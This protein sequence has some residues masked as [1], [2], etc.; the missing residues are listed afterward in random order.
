MPKIFFARSP[1][2]CHMGVLSLNTHMSRNKLINCVETI[3]ILS[4][5][6]W[7]VTTCTS[8]STRGSQTT[9]AKQQN[10][11]TSNI[12][13][14]VTHADAPIPVSQI[15]LDRDGTISATERRSLAHD[16][17]D[18]IVTFI[19]IVASVIVASIL[20]A[21]AGSRWSNRAPR[22]QARGTHRQ[23]AEEPAAPTQTEVDFLGD[24]EDHRARN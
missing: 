16:Q 18:V 23:P 5:F 1:G 19:S 6:M 13:P 12:T 2:G 22:P 7:F 15:D 10:I 21:W 17:P 11:P 20:T 24:S 4:I 14:V 8:C 3:V 9:P